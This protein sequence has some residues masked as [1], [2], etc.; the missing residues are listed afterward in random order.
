MIGI[1]RY[2]K[3]ISIGLLVFL[4][5]SCSDATSESLDRNGQPTLTFSMTRAPQDIVN[6][7]L[8]YQFN[9]GWDFKQKVYGVTVGTNQLSMTM[10]AG[11]WDIALVAA[12]TDISSKITPP[13]SGQART[14]KLWETQPT[15]TELP[16]V[17]E[18]RTA[19]LSGVPIV[20]NTTNTAG[21]EAL[22]RNVALVQVVI[23]KT[24]GLKMAAGTAHEFELNQVPTTLDWA[25]KLMPNATNPYVGAKPM[26]GTFT[27]SNKTDGSGMQESDVLSFIIPAHKGNDYLSATPADTLKNLLTLSVNLKPDGG[28]SDYIKQNIVIPRAPR[29]NN[30]LSVKLSMLSEVEISADIVDWTEVDLNATLNQTE[31]LLDKAE[32]GLAYRDT[33]FVNTNVADYTVVKDPSASWLTATKSGN[34]ILLEANTST[35]VDNSPRSSYITV[36]ANN[37]TKKI[38][39]TQRPDRGTISVDNKR[40]VFCPVSHVTRSANITTIGGD[41]QFI[42]QTY[43]A[44]PN[45]TSGTASG[46]VTFTRAAT[47]V[48]DDFDKFYGD[49]IIVVKNMKTLDT[50]TIE[51]VNCFIYMYDNTINANAPTGTALHAVTVSDDI[52]VYGGN[53][54]LINFVPGE[55]WIHTVSWDIATQKMTLTTD[56]DLDDEER[57]GT[58]AFAH[59][60]CPDY[61]VHAI[62]HQDIIITIPAFDF[63]VVKFT[64]AT[65]DV[66]I[67]VEFAGNNLAGDGTNHPDY[68]KIPVGYGMQDVNSGKGVTGTGGGSN[69]GRVSFAYKGGTLLE[70]GGD[71]TGGQGETAFFNAPLF[72]GDTNSLRK[73]K[74]EI[75]AVWWRSGT[76]PDMTFTMYAYK[77]GIMARGTGTTLSNNA[78]NF[79]NTGGVCLYSKAHLVTVSKNATDPT[80][81]MTKFEHV[82][83]VTYDR[84]KHSAAVTMHIP[85]TE[86]TAP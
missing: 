46:S 16:S 75:Y 49:S 33:I 2:I 73:I 52:T 86:T 80:N 10:D 74:L 37:I 84:V 30:I 38:P 76:S 56:R 78:Y 25:G 13:V 28:G 20:A 68:D 47:T 40:L 22:Y 39:V 77:G 55:D 1:S 60:E 36:T 3:I 5:Y 34:M 4:S 53:K 27:I 72:E 69:Y 66:D 82:A 51:I 21:P 11:T 32:V 15:A 48:E 65:N 62:V 31:L 64:W 8:V 63:F 17:P 43:K 7:T 23:D 85:F 14:G 71:A 58:M 54:N 59:A 35:Y 57:D 70:W 42:T 26:K 12:E 45:I 9:S 24:R 61:V 6:N 50:D 18:L 67:A 41:W 44:T 81:Y 29:V 83:T 19:Y 79:Y